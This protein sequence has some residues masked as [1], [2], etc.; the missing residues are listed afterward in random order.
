MRVNDLMKRPPITCDVNDTLERAA[1]LMW[2]N[3]V[4]AVIIVRE[5]G[6]MT[7]IITDRDICMSA[8]LQ[9]RVLSDLLVHSAMATHVVS[10]HPEQPIEDAEQLM[11]AHQLHRIPVVDEEQHPLGI[12][13]LNDIARESVDPDTAMKQGRARVANVLAAIARPRDPNRV[14]A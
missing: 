2:E 13:T 10:I 8:F 1:H 6:R 7:G 3:D 14:A 9:G 4:G 11:T 12:L 5:D